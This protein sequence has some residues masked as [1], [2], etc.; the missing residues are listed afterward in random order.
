MV[1]LSGAVR[2]D[3]P[4]G[5]F[6]LRQDLSDILHIP[7]DSIRVTCAGLG[8]GFG[9][10]LYAGVEPYCVL[11]AQRTGRPVRLAHTR[12]EEMIATSPRMSASTRRP[13]LKR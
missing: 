12:E 10:K 8:G 13:S 9:G 7:V 2:Q 5:P 11:L 4:R 3:G 6:G 1:G